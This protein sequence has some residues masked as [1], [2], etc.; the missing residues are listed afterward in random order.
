MTDQLELDFHKA[1][2]NVY[3]A[4]YD[5]CGYRA[6]KFKWL[7]CK[8]GGLRAAR[9]LLSTDRMTEGLVQ[10]YAAGSL[11]VSMEVMILNPKWNPLFNE[12]ER[13]MAKSRLRKLGWTRF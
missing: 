4:I 8:S 1:M 2:L 3:E 13:N 7:I 9:I 5:R 10:L 6:R 12:R 11:D